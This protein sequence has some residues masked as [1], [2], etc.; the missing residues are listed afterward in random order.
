MAKMGEKQTSVN[1]PIASSPTAILWWCSASR[2]SRAKPPPRCRGP[3][4][5]ATARPSACRAMPTR[6]RRSA[7]SAGSRSPQVSASAQ[8]YPSGDSDAPRRRVG[9]H[10][11]LGGGPT[12]VRP[13]TELVFADR[14]DLSARMAGLGADEI[15]RDEENFIDRAATR[16]YVVDE[17]SSAGRAG[18]QQRQQLCEARPRAGRG[19]RHRLRNHPR[20]GQSLLPDVLQVHSR[21][22][23]PE[24]VGHGRSQEQETRDQTP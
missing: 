7:Y 24:Q 19:R 9:R 8:H 3:S 6:R 23:D 14:D 17:R 4:P 1:P 11:F 15:A 18:R 21:G 16:A 13:V 10:P 20:V 2:R 22:L 5:S 12:A